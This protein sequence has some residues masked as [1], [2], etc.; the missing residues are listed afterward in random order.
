MKKYKDME[1]ENKNSEGAR[2]DEKK[3]ASKEEK[4]KR[5]REG[6]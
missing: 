2:N 5:N 6:K 1:K 3:N 4:A